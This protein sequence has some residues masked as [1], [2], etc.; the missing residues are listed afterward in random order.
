MGDFS[1]ETRMMNGFVTQQAPRSLVSVTKD[2][3][4]ADGNVLKQAQF[5]AVMDD[6]TIQKVTRNSK[7]SVRLL[8]GEK[9]FN[10]RYPVL[11]V[12]SDTDLNKGLG[13]AGKGFQDSEPKYKIRLTPVREDTARAI[14]Q[15]AAADISQKYFQMRARLDLEILAAFENNDKCVQSG[16]GKEC[17][18]IIFA[19]KVRGKDTNNQGIKP[20]NGARYVY[21]N[22]DIA[23]GVLC[24]DVVV[25][26]DG[27]RTYVTI[28]PEDIKKNDVV[29]VCTRHYIYDTNLAK[30]MASVLV[31]ID[32]WYK[33]DDYGAAKCAEEE[34]DDMFA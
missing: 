17:P 3:R 13:D 18:E 7:T 15:P 19:T 20:F 27:N 23:Y 5:A 25:D 4:D 33:W 9:D 10:S 26:E 11:G 32:R 12:V 21:D 34:P 2:A 6:L 28:E 30:G 14:N 8:D 31:S 24:R 22:G 1:R 16:A 29:S